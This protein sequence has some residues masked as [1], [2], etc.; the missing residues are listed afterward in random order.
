VRDMYPDGLMGEQCN[1][2]LRTYKVVSRVT[3]QLVPSESKI[4]R[5]REYIVASKY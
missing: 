2:Y 5:G 4:A 3:Q 1:V